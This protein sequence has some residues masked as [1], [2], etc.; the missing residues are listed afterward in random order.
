MRIWKW[1]CF[2]LMI[3]MG[4]LN[5]Y[6]QQDAQYGQYMFNGLYINPAYAGYKEELYV[7][8]FARAQWVGVEGG[9]RSY[10]ISADA[11]IN[12]ETLG[13]GAIIT[14]D[15]IGAQ[16]SL[17]I[18]G[19]MSY[20]LMLDKTETNVLAFGL[21]LGVVQM[22]LNG[23]LLNPTEAGD[24]R[25]PL[26]NSSSLVPTIRA[27]VHYSNEK[28]FAGFSVDNLMSKP[29]SVFDNYNQ[30]NVKIVPHYY[31]T[32]GMALPLN[33]DVIFKPTFL[34]KEDFHGPTSLDLNAF[35][36][37]KERLWFGA[38]YRTSITTYKKESKVT[39]LR[40]RASVGFM[41][42]YFVRE[43]LRLGYGYDYGLNKLNRYENGSHE[44]SIGYYFDTGKRNR[45]KCF[46]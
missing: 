45:P 36:L 37:F 15:K 13:I 14:Q 23:G 4:V 31:L 41:T 12:Y 17:K 46:F 35:L 44:I 10:S 26:G 34:I 32:A 28:F 18:S 20:R 2:S 8:A 33:D 11:A 9:P 22:G 30:I 7:Q 3:F 38:V 24:Q 29:L 5:S 16:N 39:E 1:I 42:E 43:N 21:G 25:I 6:A 40:Q 19:N 27:G